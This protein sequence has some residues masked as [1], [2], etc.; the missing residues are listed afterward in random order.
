MHKVLRMP[1]KVIISYHFSFNK[2]C[3]APNANPKCNYAENCGSHQSLRLRSDFIL[4]SSS[5][6]QRP[7]TTSCATNLTVTRHRRTSPKESPNG[8]KLRTPRRH[9]AREAN[10]VQPPHPHYKPF[11]SHS[12]KNG[13]GTTK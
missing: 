1:R 4:I 9:R 3:A 12:G 5:H 7:K 6:I 11:A 2:T 10:T 8:D 13:N